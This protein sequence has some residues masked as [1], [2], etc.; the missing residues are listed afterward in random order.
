MDILSYILSKKNNGSSTGGS[1]EITHEQAFCKLLPNESYNPADM[2]G[3]TAPDPETGA[4][5]GEIKLYYTDVSNEMGREVSKISAGTRFIFI[6]KQ[7]ITTMETSV[8]IYGNSG[9]TLDYDPSIFSE[10]GCVFVSG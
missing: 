3:L 8:Y 6:M 7:N 1:S 10:N 2:A 4:T 9:I 5:V